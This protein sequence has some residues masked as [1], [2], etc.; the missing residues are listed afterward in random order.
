[1]APTNFGPDT[2]Q[3][4]AAIATNLIELEQFMDFLRSRTF[5]ETLL[6]RPGLNRVPNY[7]LQPALLK[8]MHIASSLRPTSSPLDLRP[9]VEQTFESITNF[10]VKS[11]SPLVKSAFLTLA[12][13]FP[14]S[15]P[16]ELLVEQAL[17][18][19]KRYKVTVDE[20]LERA[21]TNIGRALLTLFTTSEAI[22]VR[23]MASPFVTTPSERPTASLFA[24]VQSV[25][26]EP[27]TT[28]RHESTALDE[29]GRAVLRLLD[30]T[31]T[32]SDI[33]KQL[34]Q[35]EKEVRDWI[36]RLGRTALLIA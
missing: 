4:L 19:L 11:S 14:E 6:H 33:A 3:A 17:Q 7:T 1:M 23:A 21:A 10:P 34:A 28:R 27:I 15:I 25:D 12:L 32:A 5:R 20:T 29:T 26:Y 36:D 18:Q 2:E 35:P 30:G 16:F 9:G 13:K 8:G 31:R 24:R 22:E